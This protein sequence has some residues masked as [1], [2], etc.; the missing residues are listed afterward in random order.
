VAERRIICDN[1]K[2]V[3]R[4]SKDNTTKEDKM[5]CIDRKFKISAT[6][7]KSG[8]EY[9]QANAVVF[10]AKDE[11]LPDLLDR[12]YAMCVEHKV[13]ARQLLGVALLKERVVAWQRKN[14]KK[15]HLPDVEEGKEEKRVC[16]DNI[17]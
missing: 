16:K 8:K 15:V 2:R 11:L 4:R 3:N 1:F 5:E 7:L 14:I 6:S 17:V 13:D 10:L 12:Y 9:T